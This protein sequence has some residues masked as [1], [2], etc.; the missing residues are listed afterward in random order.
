MIG[1]ERVPVDS[2]FFFALFNERD[3]HRPLDNRNPEGFRTSIP[4]PRNFD[5]EGIL[6]SACQTLRWHKPDVPD[7]A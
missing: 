3:R 7:M 5:P 6:L 1:P 2:G 4:V